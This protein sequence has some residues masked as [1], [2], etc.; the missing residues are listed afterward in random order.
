MRSQLLEQF[1]VL[2][3]TLRILPEELVKIQYFINTIKEPEEG[4]S[5]IEVA[6]VNVFNQIYAM[7]CSLK[8]SKHIESI[9]DCDAI[10]TTLCIRHV[11]QHQSGRIKNNLRDSFE[12][13]ISN[14]SLMVQYEDTSD[15]EFL[16][17]IHWMQQEIQKSNNAGKLDSINE[18]WNFNAIR[19]EIE[20]SSYNWN[21]C[22]VSVMALIAESIRQIV[23]N[24]GDYFSPTG[25]D[26]DVYYKHFNDVNK[27]NT[28]QYQIITNHALVP[29][30]CVG[31]FL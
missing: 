15:S 18:Y 21:E 8:D 31:M 7:M 22:Y 4:I 11:L 30:L 6:C 12:R 1:D 3:N 14:K 13:T 9:Y 28:S 17:N 2:S 16:I 19:K 25:Y 29:T 23:T 5:N 10:T 20:F 24:Y 26:S 27:T